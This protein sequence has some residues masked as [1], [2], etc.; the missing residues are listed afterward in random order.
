MQIT[1]VGLQVNSYGPYA[2]PAIVDL[3]IT[4]DFS[5]NRYFWCFLKGGIFSTETIAICLCTIPYHA[6]SVVDLREILRIFPFYFL[7]LFLYLEK[8]GNNDLKTRLFEAEAHYSADS[9]QVLEGLEA[10]RKAPLLCI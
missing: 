2:I 3:G 6:I 10:V 4:L 1:P 7:S 8:H 9:I 5:V